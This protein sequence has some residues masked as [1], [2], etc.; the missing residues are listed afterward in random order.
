MPE[1][2]EPDLAWEALPEAELR[3]RFGPPT[4]ETVE[5]LKDRLDHLAHRAP[6][7]ALH[8]AR[9]LVAYAASG[10]PACRALAQLALA[11]AFLWTDRLGEALSAYDEAQAC[12][13]EAA[14]LVLRARCGIGKM[15]ALF[16]QGR[17]E[18]ALTLADA[19]EPVLAAAG[20]PLLLARV[21]SQRATVLKHR[22]DL[23]GAVEAYTRAIALLR[24]AEGGALDLTIALHNL[25]LGL[26]RLGRGEEALQRLEEARETARE[27]RSALWEARVAAAVGELDICLG[28]YARAIAAFEQAANLYE[29]AGI[30]ATAAMYRL[31]AVEGWLYLGRWERVEQEAGQLAE[32]LYARGFAA[33]AARA[34]Y[35]LALA[36]RQAGRWAEA[37]T[38]LRQAASSF[39]AS[40]RTLWRA[41]VLAELSALRLRRGATEEAASLLQEAYAAGASQDTVG[42]VRILLVEA[43]LH[44]ARG[45]LSAAI[46]A[47]RAALRAGRRLRL[48]WACAL[49]HRRLAQLSSSPHRRR[50]HLLSGIAYA[51]RLLAAV[52]AD[53]R[54]STYREFQQ[55]YGEG[56]RAL[57]EA[58]QPGRAWAVAQGMK[59]QGM[60][61][62]LTRDPTA[63][64]R[65]RTASEDS[66]LQ[67]LQ[68]L[69]TQYRVLTSGTLEAP[70][71][72]TTLR[73]LERRIHELVE[74]LAVYGAALDD[75]ALLGF[76][77]APERPSLGSEG[78][79]VEYLVMHDELLAFCL[80]DRSVRI[81]RDLA[82]L[83]EVHRL[84][85][86][87]GLGLHA[88]ASGHLPPQEAL[89]QITR[90][91]RE[92]YALLL[93]PLE[94]A[95]AGCRRLVLAPSGPLFGLP[96]HAF[97]WR[98]RC[99]WE[100]WEV[101]YIPAGSLLPLLDRRI[102]ARGPMVLLAS[103]HGGQIPQAAEEVARIA[104][105]IPARVIWEPTREVFLSEL[106]SC[107][108]LHFAGHCV[109]HQ[110]APLL[111]ALHL[112]D[113]PLT[114]LDLLEAPARV[115]LVVL[116]GCSTGAHAVLPGDELFGFARAWLRVGARG[117]VLSLWPAEDRSTCQLMEAFYR[118]LVGGAPPAAALRTAAL[119]VRE[120]SPHPLHWA[121]FLYMGSPRI[122]LQPVDSPQTPGRR[123]E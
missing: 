93:Q 121:G 53:L 58:G 112:A 109:F 98:D 42:F 17:G 119:Q 72:P 77:H 61:Q 99:V 9:V 52:P 51:H 96:F 71:G 3:A 50:V 94:P 5:T 123:G 47:A 106:R 64:L 76:P 69:H 48:P 16:L 104:R 35:L 82:P 97:L 67:E 31:R 11:N 38:L 75:A 107:T 79:L 90:V 34:R 20:Q 8:G 12:A 19:I 103:T 114:L 49:A 6:A 59:A 89:M 86:W 108:L 24:G 44:A 33:E 46:R 80:R 78:A 28:R 26:L 101:S 65:A 88:Y 81:F 21:L 18:E 113:G 70:A 102:P 110:E 29:Q 57:A 95:L 10:D 66:L 23:E 37:E 30:V 45:A 32:D 13:E 14:D 117:L 105:W 22:G 27:A 68:R 118:E 4:P 60:A 92:L 100:D 55:L 62:L 15:G 63:H 116:S 122:R 54:W 7:A 1:V 111:S 56:L 83:P 2:S 91:L 74:R 115:D 40:Q 85:R 84:A 41:A 39:A 73:A 25:A 36:H 87:L 43:D 120:T